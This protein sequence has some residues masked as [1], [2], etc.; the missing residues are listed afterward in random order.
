MSTVFSLFFVRNSPFRVS[1]PITTLQ[2]QS[3]KIV[4][5]LKCTYNHDETALLYSQISYSIVC[6]QYCDKKTYFDSLVE[7]SIFGFSVLK[8]VVYQTFT[9]MYVCVLMQG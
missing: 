2:Q 5:K 1:V 3:L 4:V 7:V 8:R 6:T 9:F